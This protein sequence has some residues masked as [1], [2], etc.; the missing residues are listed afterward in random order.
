L[1]TNVN[2]SLPVNTSTLL[3]VYSA[4]VVMA[5]VTILVALGIV[6]ATLALGR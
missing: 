2:Q 6:P 1:S 5:L 3:G 4:M